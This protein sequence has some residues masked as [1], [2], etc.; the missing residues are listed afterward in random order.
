MNFTACAY[1]PP[2][3]VEPQESGV[4]NVQ[5]SGTQDG[6]DNAIVDDNTEADSDK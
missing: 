5:E 3:M 4:T 1:G 6:S 2:T